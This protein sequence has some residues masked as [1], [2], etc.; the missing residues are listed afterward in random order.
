MM[1]VNPKSL[2]IAASAYL[3]RLEKV[4]TNSPD[5]RDADVLAVAQ[6]FRKVIQDNFSNDF[7]STMATMQTA[8]AMALIDLTESQSMTAVQREAV[9]N[10]FGAS[11][12]M[13]YDLM[14]NPPVE[15]KP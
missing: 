11:L 3:D 10:N 4:M 8:L 7:A 14:R 1:A 15:N 9:Y 2:K 6:A 13:A 5:T 12:K